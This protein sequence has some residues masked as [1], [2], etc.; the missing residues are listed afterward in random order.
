MEISFRVQM[1]LVYVS[2]GH[3]P[4]Y[5]VQLIN[6]IY[7]AIYIWHITGYDITS[8]ISTTMEM[9]CSQSNGSENY[10]QL[11]IYYMRDNVI[12]IITW[13]PMW[14]LFIHS[15]TKMAT[16]INDEVTFYSFSAFFTTMCYG[17]PAFCFYMLAFKLLQSQYIVYIYLLILSFGIVSNIMLQYIFLYVYRWGA[18]GAALAVSI[19]FYITSVCS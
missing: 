1:Y 16:F 2:L 8:C 15:D 12:A 11:G 3:L 19:S 6:R 18:H 10:E 13:F 5:S 9:Y 7:F 17:Y 14:A 4:N